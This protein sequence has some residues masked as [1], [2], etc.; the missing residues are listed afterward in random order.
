MKQ[1]FT[2][3][4][5]CISLFLGFTFINEK[6]EKEEISSTKETQEENSIDKMLEEKISSMTLEEKIAQILLVR[7]PQENAQEIIK[8]NQFGGIVLYAS[9]FKNLT[10]EEV[11]AKIESFQSVSKIPLITAV[12]EEGGS[13]V[14]I[15]SN[16]NLRAT[17]F[18]SPRELYQIGGLEKIKE[19]T[20]E[21]SALL[22]SLGINVNLA[23]VVDIS[24]NEEDYIYPRSLGEGKEVTSLYAVAVIEASKKGKVSYTL[25]HFPGYGQNK[26]THQ[27]ESKDERTIDELKEKD[28]LPFASGIK[29][30]AEAI[31][32]SHSILSKIDSENPASLSLPIHKLLRDDLNFKGIIITDDLSMGATKEIENAYSKAI[33]SENDFIITSDYEQA[34][35]EIKES[36]N[37]NRIKEE[38]INKLVKHVLNWKKEKGLLS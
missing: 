6:K 3:L 28:L 14:R 21:K 8:E 31:L 29:A 32:V 20:E 16:P 38:D 24:T 37:Q 10:K 34:L 9:D 23:P 27:T 1:F 33:L 25:K 35:T 12:D 17:P 18:L 26:D 7:T 13:V 5:L 36:I 11:I 2:V 19:D 30:G 22:E 4:L 15:S